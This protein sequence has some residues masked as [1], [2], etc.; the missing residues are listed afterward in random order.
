VVEEAPFKVWFLAARS[1]GYGH[2]R[3]SV[4]SGEGVQGE[5]PAF[6]ASCP[7]QHCRDLP[8]QALRF[9]FVSSFCLAL[10]IAMAASV[11][12]CCWANCWSESMLMPGLRYLSHCAV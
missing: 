1:G 8:C 9:T 5:G 4:V 2:L 6:E 3:G 12:V 7:A 11:S 10:C